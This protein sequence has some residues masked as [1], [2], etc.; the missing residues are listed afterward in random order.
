[1]M[2]LLEMIPFPQWI[3]HAPATSFLMKGMNPLPVKRRKRF[4]ETGRSKGGCKSIGGE[5]FHLRWS[6]RFGEGGR[7]ESGC[8]GW[9][10]WFFPPTSPEFLTLN[11]SHSMR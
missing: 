11:I 5:D 4:K 7:S 8:N 9:G 1:M 6:E 10:G 3:F 2:M